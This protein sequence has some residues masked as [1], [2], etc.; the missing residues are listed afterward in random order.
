MPAAPAAGAG[1]AQDPTRQHLRGSSLLLAGRLLTLGIHFAAQL[2]IVRHFAAGDYG[3]FAWALAAMALLEGAVTLGLP[4]GLARFVPSCHE[5]GERRRM[6]A[7]IAFAAALVAGLGA[8]LA[9]AAW[10]APDWLAR[11]SGGRPEP[12]ALLAILLVAIPIE[13]L[14]RLA[15]SVFASFARAGAIFFRRHV[16][17]P[18]LRL[19][20]VL[21]CL[22][23]GAGPVF[24]AYSYVAATALG[25]AINGALLLRLL[26]SD[27]ARAQP[28][29]AQLSSAP[30]GLPWRELALLS[31]PLCA[32]ELVAL[33]AH[34]IPTLLLG[35][36]RDPAEVASLRAIL[37]AANLNTLVM[38]SFALLYTPV[39]SRLLARGERAALGR[40]YWRTAV[41]MALLSFPIFALT[42]PLAEPVTRLLY[43]ERYAASAELLRIL[44]AAY[45]LNAALG[46]N[47]LT[48]KLLGRLRA[49]LAIDAL[50]LGSNLALAL[51]LVPRHGALGAALAT[52]GS[53]VLQNALSQ[54][55]LRWLAGIR[56]FEW[57]F[58]SLYALLGAAA[59]GLLFVQRLAEPP[60]YLGVALAAL[61]SGAVLALSRGRLELGE[62][63]PELLRLP[64]LGWLA[65]G[66]RERGGRRPAG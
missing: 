35:Y 41:W 7:G 40:L 58:A 56:A 15:V 62:T 52:A 66:A 17:A 34:A 37:P 13:G 14:E 9:A 47:N 61:V 30:P 22:L 49:T 25:L 38:G 53:L 11:V 51:W 42:A 32:S 54:A 45:Y 3:A 59:A 43:G 26:R 19:G 18:G 55:G 48:L 12:V 21:L 2:L 28:G 33:A 20:V 6:L 46:F 50:A 44:A 24:L 16:L 4:G 31:L 64:G 1:A 36:H 57:R 39:L 8:L 5:R 27:G 65:R 10:A 23:Q 60:L 29:S 63:F